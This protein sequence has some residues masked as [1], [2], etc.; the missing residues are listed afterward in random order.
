LRVEL[1]SASDKAALASE[2][3]SNVGLT[4][5]RIDSTL[6]RQNVISK[7]DIT[8]SYDNY[9]NYKN[10][11]LQ[12]EL[13]RNQ[14]QSASNSLD[15]DYLK[16][17][18]ALDLKVIELQER[19]KELE[20][21]KTE[22]DKQLT[23][24]TDNLNYLKTQVLKQYII[25]ETDGEVQNLHNLKF[26]ANFINKDELLLSVTPKKGKFFAKV[27]IPQR[28][29]RHVKVGQE[30]HLK[31]EAFN[32]YDQGILM[33]NVSYVPEG[34][35]KEDF[36]VII[37]LPRTKNFQLKA[38]YALRGEIIVE[39]LTILKFIAKKLFRK[40]GDASTPAPTPAP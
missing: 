36:F 13:T 31:V 3:M 18:N 11:F 2:Q 16:T 21:Q 35:P 8:N 40:I 9:S 14:I 15:N 37:D 32:F 5:L 38:G 4:K 27:T 25:A 28:D 12:S 39:R 24:A 7:L 17:Q 22:T 30:V 26:K 23:T 6:Y 10:S 19:L 20:R 33:G 34:K 1:K 29:M